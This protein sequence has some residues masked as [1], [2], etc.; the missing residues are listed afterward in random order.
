MA[1]PDRIATTRHGPMRGSP[2]EDTGPI[3]LRGMGLSV[4]VVSGGQGVGG[5]GGMDELRQ[6]TAEVGHA[7]KNEWWI[8]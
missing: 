2:H 7:A 1:I 3:R 8:C 4:G 5:N 6:A